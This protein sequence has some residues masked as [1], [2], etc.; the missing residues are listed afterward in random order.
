MSDKTVGA[1]ALK[2]FNDLEANQQSVVDANHCG[3]HSSNC[4][5]LCLSCFGYQLEEELRIVKIFRHFVP[6][7]EMHPVPGGGMELVFA[8]ESHLERAELVAKYMVE[9]NVPF[10]WHSG[11]MHRGNWT[12]QEL[13]RAPKLWERLLKAFFNYFN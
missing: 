12:C 3:C 9:S 8:N 1:S 11:R 2:K 10:K 4:C 5:C 6:V 7:T 13:N